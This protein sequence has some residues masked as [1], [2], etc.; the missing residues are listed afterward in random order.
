MLRNIKSPIS[1]DLQKFNKSMDIQI[2]KENVGKQIRPTVLFLSKRMIS[3]END[4]NVLEIAR[5]IEQIHYASILH[6]DVVD[7]SDFRRNKQ[8]FN[9]KFD[10]KKAVLY[11]DYLFSDV[12]YKIASLENTE[13]SKSMSTILVNLSSGE[14]NQIENVFNVNYSENEYIEKTYNKTACM[15]A[16]SMK[17]TA[18]LYDERYLN[19]FYGIG[20]TFGMMYQI[21]DDVLD[22]SGSFEKMKK[23]TGDDLK[24]GIVTMPLIDA[25]NNEE[26]LITYKKYIRT[27]N[28]YL[29]YILF[30]II[31]ENYLHNTIELA[32]KYKKECIN[33]ID[34]LEVDNIY[35][36]NLKSLTYY[37]YNR[38]K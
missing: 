13:I 14:L 27:K 4:K 32:R 6:D 12:S 7:E 18:L 26:V 19:E 34:N 23:G 20:K 28:T 33:T 1:V 2:M 8:T 17:V 24:N 15:F 37:V 38:L 25:L 11:G 35:K 31:K 22:Y 21:V 5:I 30:D 9:N 36:D 10:N 16:E 29:Y 3:K